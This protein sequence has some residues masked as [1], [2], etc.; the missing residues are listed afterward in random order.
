MIFDRSRN[1]LEVVRNFMEFFVEENCGYCTPCRAGN[2]ILLT[3]LDRVMSGNGTQEDLEVLKDLGEKI[4]IGSR[5]GLGQ[6]SP[7]PILTS[8][9]NFRPLYESLIR[10]PTDGLKR[11]FDVEEALR[12]SVAITGR[13]STVL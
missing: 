6:T 12:E 4:K 9:E 8:L 3:L 2:R 10:K 11:S 5:C 7:N 1:L 13:Q